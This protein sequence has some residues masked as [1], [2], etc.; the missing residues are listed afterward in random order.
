MK[1]YWLNNQSFPLKESGKTSGISMLLKHEKLVHLLLAKFN[2]F[3]ITYSG[4]Q[5]ISLWD[6]AELT[7]EEKA[8]LSKIRYSSTLSQENKDKATPVGDM[9]IFAELGSQYFKSFGYKGCSMS[10]CYKLKNAKIQWS[11]LAHGLITFGIFFD[12]CE[13]ECE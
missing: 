7:D 8:I 3:D 1:N 13:R 5:W 4:T 12:E 11:H 6:E 2:N 10:M 9:E